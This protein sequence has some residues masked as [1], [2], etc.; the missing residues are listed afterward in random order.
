M[1]GGWKDLLQIFFKGRKDPHVSERIKDPVC[2]VEVLF[3]IEAMSDGKDPQVG[4]FCSSN[5]CPGIFKSNGKVRRLL[6]TQ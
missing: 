1:S 2:F 5:S 4:R 3:V 6:Q